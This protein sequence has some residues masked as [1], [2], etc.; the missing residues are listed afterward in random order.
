LLI[1]CLKGPNRYFRL[2]GA[3]KFV[4]ATEAMGLHQKVFNT[5]ALCAVDMNGDGACDL[6]LN[7]EAQASAALLGN[8]ERVA[9]AS[10]K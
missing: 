6:L 4:D 9:S 7:N 2:G 8:V 3:G 10:D 1:G 5:R